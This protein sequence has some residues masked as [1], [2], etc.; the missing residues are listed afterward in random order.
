MFDEE[1][2]VWIDR[3][4]KLIERD[5]KEIYRTTKYYTMHTYQEQ[6]HSQDQRDIG[7]SVNTQITHT[8]F[9]ACQE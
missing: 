9:F 6:S 5:G 4:K 2:V 1:K 7:K 3:E 8:L